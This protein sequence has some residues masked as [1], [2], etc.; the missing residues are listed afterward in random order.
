MK[1]L[2]INSHH[3]FYGGAERYYFDLSS[4]LKSKGHE[5]AHFSMLDRNNQASKWSKYFVS[6]LDF[7]EANS[8]SFFKKVSRMFYS[9]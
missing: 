1:I 3:R 5:V 7:S 4:L 9:L 6:N 2:L 8:S